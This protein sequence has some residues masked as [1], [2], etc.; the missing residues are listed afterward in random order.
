MQTKP[1]YLAGGWRDSDDALSKKYVAGTRFTETYDRLRPLIPLLRRSIEYVVMV[2]VVTLVIMQVE[3]I[4]D[5]AEWGPRIIQIIG[6]VFMAR[7]VKELAV[8]VLEETM[9]RKSGNATCPSLT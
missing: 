1:F 3:A 7:V 8:F 4:A 6:I 5:L 2:T 9:L